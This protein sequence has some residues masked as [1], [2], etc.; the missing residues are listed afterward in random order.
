MPQFALDQTD[1]TLTSLTP[2]VEKHGDDEVQA[3]TLGISITAGN[4]ILSA[5]DERLA[6]MLYAADE[7]QEPLPGITPALTVLRCPSIKSLDIDFVGEGYRCHISHGIDDDGTI[8]MGGCKIKSLR[9]SPMPGG[10]VELSLKINT[11][12]IAEQDVGLLWSKLGGPIVVEA[13]PPSLATLPEGDGKPI[14]GTGQ[15]G[16]PLGDE[17]TE[18]FLEANS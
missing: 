4:A 1:A 6:A 17:A 11:S 7:D 10:S 14:D 16:L 5:I 3:I 9:V 8:T 18:A 2:R 15:G 12:D 13:T